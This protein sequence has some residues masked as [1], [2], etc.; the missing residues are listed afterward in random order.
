MPFSDLAKIFENKIWTAIGTWGL[1]GAGE[2]PPL[3]HVCS[4]FATTIAGGFN[5]RWTS[6]FLQ[7]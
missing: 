1:S 2:L 6:A 7:Q 3:P 4:I 5:C